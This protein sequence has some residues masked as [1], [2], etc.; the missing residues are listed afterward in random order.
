M[1]EAKQAAAHKLPLTV[2][3]TTQ[4]TCKSTYKGANS[5]DIQKC[6]SRLFAQQHSSCWVCGTLRRAPYTGKQQADIL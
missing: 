4:S 6:Y 2:T 5:A 3:Q 1:P